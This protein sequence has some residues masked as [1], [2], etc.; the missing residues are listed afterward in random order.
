M[1]TNQKELQG[2]TALVTGS[3]S[4]IGKATATALAELGASVVVTGRNP[5]RGAAVVGRSRLPAVRLGSW[6]PIWATWTRSRSWRVRR[7]TSTSWSTTPAIPGSA[8]PPISTRPASTGYSP[9][10]CARPTC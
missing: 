1:T 10:T 5:E 4:G 3:T 7:A 8:R 6:Q 2:T 9:A